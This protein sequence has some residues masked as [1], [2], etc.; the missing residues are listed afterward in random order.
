MLTENL[1]DYLRKSF[2]P[3]F[4]RDYAVLR[5]K[6]LCERY[7]TNLHIIAWEFKD[8]TI[9]QIDETYCLIISN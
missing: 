9:Q 8:E 4:T 7:N 6:S 5:L 3:A 1:K 2:E